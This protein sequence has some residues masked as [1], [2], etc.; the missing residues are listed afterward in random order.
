MSPTRHL[1]ICMA[2]L[3]LPFAAGLGQVLSKQPE[4]HVKALCL[5]A[6]ADY[7]TW[8]GSQDRSK[9][10]VVGILG[11]S[12]FERHLEVLYATKPIK[13]R[14]VELTYLSSPV[15]LNRCHILFIC[16]SESER[17][18]NI[19]RLL[20]GRPVLTIGDTPD[21]AHRGVM[22]NLVMV[23]ERIQFE[24]NLNAAKASGMEISSHVLKLA[25][26]VE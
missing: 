10:L 13:G 20:R 21:F 14:K 9:P 2:M 25:K 4:Y 17:L 12:R 23:N 26:L 1:L 19:L 3:S 22:I 16:D 5:G 7:V 15:G 8:P 6:L 18:S 11:T 24:V